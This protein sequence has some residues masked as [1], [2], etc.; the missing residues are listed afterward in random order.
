M[1][2]YNK[3]FLVITFYILTLSFVSAGETTHTYRNQRGSTLALKWNKSVD[4]N[5]QSTGNLT[6]TFVSAVGKC[7]TGLSLPVTGVFN[8]NAIAITLNLPSCKQVIAMTGHTTQ[9][10]TEIHMLWLDAAQSADPQKTDWNSNI[11]GTDHY[12]IEK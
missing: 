9:D 11:I 10:K 1:R 7:A 12:K 3:L 5:D 2:R 6:G 8:G 4:S